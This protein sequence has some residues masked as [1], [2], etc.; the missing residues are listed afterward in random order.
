MK[1]QIRA[2]VDLYVNC[3]PDEPSWRTIVSELYSCDEIAAARE[4]KQFYYRNGNCNVQ[5]KIDTCMYLKFLCCISD[6]TLTVSNL[7]KIMETVKSFRRREVWGRLLEWY[8]SVPS[9]LNEV[10][11]TPTIEMEMLNTL[12]DVYVNIRPESSWQHLVKILYV[13]CELKASK[14]AKSFLVPYGELVCGDFV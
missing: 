9:Y 12:A 6:Q 3:F 8:K 13:D 11:V 4:A 1:E 10:Y 2:C 7:V 14:E 5:S